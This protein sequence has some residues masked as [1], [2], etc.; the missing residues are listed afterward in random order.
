MCPQDLAAASQLVA[1]FVLG[2]LSSPATCALPLQSGPRLLGQS[3]QFDPH[4]RTHRR[5]DADF[6]DVGTSDA[7]RLAAGDRADKGAHIIRQIRF[8]KACLADTGMYDPRPLG[9]ELDLPAL[10][11]LH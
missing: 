8:G 5:A 1:V 7:A 2:P 10:G 4:A 9:A 3:G 6:L 11:G